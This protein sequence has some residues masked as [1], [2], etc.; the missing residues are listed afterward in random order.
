M[1]KLCKWRKENLENYGYDVWRIDETDLLNWRMSADAC[2]ILIFQQ[3]I[4]MKMY[5]QKYNSSNKWYRLYHDKK[6]APYLKLV[7]SESC[8]FNTGSNNRL[9]K[10]KMLFN[11]KAKRIKLLQNF[12]KS[13]GIILWKHLLFRLL[14]ISS[15][16]F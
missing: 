9:F 13:A 15:K 6:K 12:Q 3:Q 4:K 1:Q 14:F 5:M 8:N 16:S 7:F 10:Y 11:N 2:Y